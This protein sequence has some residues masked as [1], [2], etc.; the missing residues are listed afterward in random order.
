M[1]NDLTERTPALPT[2][3]ESGSLRAQ[4][5][6]QI[7]QTACEQFLLH[8]YSGTSVDSIVAIVGGSKATIYALFGSKEGLLAEVVGAVSHDGST[9]DLPEHPGDLR[10]ELTA[11]ACERMARVLSPLHIGIQQVV[12]AEAQRL[13]RIAS[14]YF[15]RG[16]RPS[17]TALTAYLRGAL[18]RGLLDIFDVDRAARAFLG[19]LLFRPYLER[20][21]GVAAR[22]DAD[23]IRRDAAAAVNDFL[24]RHCGASPP[25]IG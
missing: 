18:E 15:D 2:G 19:E 7:I 13:P 9:P 25:A 17:Y 10:A 5:R 1:A 22:P 4:R 23:A 24:A 8:G 20:M 3:G 12:I 6:A 21:F 16:P 14:L 11:F